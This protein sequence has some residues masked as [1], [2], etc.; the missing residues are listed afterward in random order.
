MTNKIIVGSSKLIDGVLDFTVEAE[1]GLPV[2]SFDLNFGFE[3]SKVRAISVTDTTL[4]W[5]VIGNSVAGAFLVGGYSIAPL[6]SGILFRVSITLVYPTDINLNLSISGVIN[7]PAL[8]LADQQL[9]LSNGKV[10][11]VPVGLPHITGSMVEDQTLAVDLTGVSDG[12]GFGAFAYQW[13]RNGLLIHGANSSSYQLEDADSGKQISLQVSYTDGRGNFELISAQATGLIVNV[14]DLPTGGVTISGTAEP[15]R[16][17]TATNTLMDA[18]GMGS[19]TYTWKS[20]ATVLGTGASLLLDQTH[21]GQA[22]TVTA[23][24]TDGFNSLESQS[25]A[26]TV[27][28]ANMNDAP[29]FNFI[30]EGKLTINLPG[31]ATSLALQADGRIVVTGD[32]SGSGFSLARINVDGTI[33]ATFSGDGKQITQVGSSSTYGKS[34]LIQDDGKILTAGWSDYPTLVALTRYT[35][36]GA[37][38]SSF[39]ADGKVTT[40]LGLSGNSWAQDMALQAD[41]K[42]LVAG[43]A[44]SGQGQ[45]DFALARYDSQGNLDNSFSGDGKLTTNIGPS[46]TASENCEGIAVQHDGKIVLAGTSYAGG[47]TGYDFA[48]ARY[49]SNGT[50]DTTFDGDGKMTLDFGYANDLGRDVLIQPDDKILVVGQSY[51]GMQLKIALARLNSNGTLDASFSDD[52]LITAQLGPYNNPSLTPNVEKFSVA[53]QTNGKILV[54]GFSYNNNPDGKLEFVLVR[55]NPDGTL[56]TTFSGDGIL[57]TTFDGYVMAAG[58]SVAVQS[59]G[60]IVVAGLVHDG[61]Q[62]SLGLVRYNEDGSVDSDF[63]IHNNLGS[64]PEY[65]EDGAPVLLDS[66]VEISDMELDARG[67]YAGAVVSLSRQGGANL[68]DTFSGSGNLSFVG[69]STVLSGITIGSVVNAAGTLTITFNSNATPADV[70]ETLSSIAYANSSNSPPGVV[71]IDW[72]FSDGNVEDQGEGGVLYGFGSTVVSITAVNDSTT[73]SVTITG[74]ARQG[75][76]LTAA[77]TLADVDGLGTISYQWKADGTAI[78]GATAAIYTLTQEQVGKVITVTASYTDWQGTAEAVSSVATVAVASANS[79]PIARD[80]PVSAI[81]DTLLSGRFLAVDPDGDTLSYRIVQGPEHGTVSL[82]SDGSFLYRPAS[83]FNGLDSF[84]YMASDGQ[85]ESNEATVSLN[86]QAVND[87]PLGTGKT[88]TISEDTSLVLSPE[89]FGFR[90]V[91]AADSL[92]AVRFTIIASKGNI[93]LNGEAVTV[94]QEIA[95]SELQAGH[96]VYTPL[97]NGFGAPYVNLRFQVSDGQEFSRASYM[98]SVK[99]NPVRDDLVLYGT[100]GN[101]TINGDLIDVGSLDQLY[102][103]AGNDRLIGRYARDTIVGGTGADTIYGGDGSDILKFAAGD[104]G[105]VTGFDV[106]ADYQRGARSTG[107]LIDYAKSMTIGGTAAVATA[108]QASINASTGVATFASGSGMTMADALADVAARMTAASDAAGEMAF[109]QVSKKGHMMLFIS[110]GVA[111]ATANDVVVQLMGISAINQIDLTGGNLTLVS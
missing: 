109:F 72:V 64:N 96:L 8:N 108:T 51:G 80:T 63:G 17:L 68:S 61:T 92:Q 111:G 40:N 5:T 57:S 67:N 62:F 13:M 22:I 47:A 15:G 37:L 41:G 28:V 4:G 79:E 53:L 3:S 30:G 14:N 26:A 81:E 97:A 104:S 95:V 12:D 84:Q 89:V 7:D 1:G 71:P 24:Y 39:N 21:V 23:S 50:L 105:Q 31:Q 70:D 69:S 6:S 85:L 83:N 93:L 82:S 74:T 103:L 77:N 36:D 16:T 58:S 98:L 110:D 27:A 55:Y 44:E 9:S 102:G 94:G 87:A 59:N 20:G 38:D 73:G 88:W 60:Q 54:A 78:S 99:V 2:E 34:V 52:G 10:N 75:Q 45:R 35:A 48:L 91:D 101:D 76:S 65:V 49:N 46:I 106:V 86:V 42:I 66:T 11:A 56:D 107:D 90:D 43:V 33:D 29:R 18:E 32:A 25:S 100:D 19:V